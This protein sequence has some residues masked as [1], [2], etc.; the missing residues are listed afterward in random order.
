M[1]DTHTDGN[2]AAGM[3]DRILAVE[4]TMLMRTCQACGDRQPLGA[5]PA[6]HGAV[7]VLRCP[8]CDE[9]AVR[10]G[11]RGEGVVVEWRGVYE[12]V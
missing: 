5:H 2:E 6:Y 1:T 12:I 4:A 8:S 11:E 7:T 3:L 9:V 10:V